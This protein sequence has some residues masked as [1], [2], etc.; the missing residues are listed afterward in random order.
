MKMSSKNKITGHVYF[1]SK[2]KSKEF[3]EEL[4]KILEISENILSNTDESLVSHVEK[5]VELSDNFNLIKTNNST[6]MNENTTLLNHLKV[7]SQ[8]FKEI[9]EEYKNMSF[10]KGEKAEQK[11]MKEEDKNKLKNT[12]VKFFYAIEQLMGLNNQSFTQL[13]I[14][15]IKNCLTKLNLFQGGLPKQEFIENAKLIIFEADK[16]IQLVRT[17]VTILTDEYASKKMEEIVNDFEIS[18]K[19]LIKKMSAS[20]SNVE[21]KNEVKIYLKKQI[22]KKKKFFLQFKIKN[23]TKS[24]SKSKI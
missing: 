18:I 8:T 16:L 13:I 2:D 10:I 21:F 12:I 22:Y 1:Q 19:E 5:L 23:Q 15:N 6:S 17:R 7:F 24:N 4:Y 3:M 9:F 20:Y 11:E 14:D